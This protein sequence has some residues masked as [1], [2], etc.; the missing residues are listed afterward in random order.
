MEDVQWS[1]DTSNESLPC[2]SVE[3]DNLKRLTGR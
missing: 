1:S 2:Q 3:T